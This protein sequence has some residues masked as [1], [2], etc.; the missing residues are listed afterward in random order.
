MKNFIVSLT[1]LT[2]LLCA[3]LSSSASTKNKKHQEE[4]IKTEKNKLKGQEWV[5]RKEKSNKN[6][7]KNKK[8]GDKN[9]KPKQNNLKEEVREWK[10]RKAAL[11]PLQLKDII[12]EN[13]RL[14]VSN[15]KLEEEIEN[16]KVLQEEVE[17]L[18]RLR[19]QLEVQKN[20]PGNQLTNG[21]DVRTDSQTETH[22]SYTT[23]TG[24]S[25]GPHRLRSR[26]D[27]SPSRDSS[28]DK[29]GRPNAAVGDKVDK[30]NPYTP[31]GGDVG[32]RGT[33]ELEAF[34]SESDRLS[35]VLG[36]LGFDGLHKDDWATDKDGQPYIKGIIFKVQIGAYKKRDLN[37][38]L[39]SKKA[40]ETFEQEQSGGINK[41]TLRYF[42]D[43]WK[44]NKFKR[45]IRAMGLKDAWIVVF[46][47]GKR[48]PLKEALQ[49]V[50]KS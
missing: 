43:Y 35:A 33:E 38:L 28:I 50:L 29:Q 16:I 15:R 8:E 5:K 27:E 44:A 18:N 11:E 23:G 24:R 17:R 49:K 41:Y 6:K 26:S 20:E 10:K 13:H 34:V 3:T 12:E 48:I 40:Q 47:D 32:S 46:Q 7:R 37:N 22:V 1:L 42:R 39:E 31:E 36:K 14:K 9:K 25:V 2:A 21:P 30:S 19:T 4:K 45:E